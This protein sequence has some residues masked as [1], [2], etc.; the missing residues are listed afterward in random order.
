MIRPRRIARPHRPANV[1]DGLG[2]LLERMSETELLTRP[3]SFL[4]VIDVP[5]VEKRRENVTAAE[6]WPGP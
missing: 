4:A 1:G 5:A 2:G 6:R 3:A